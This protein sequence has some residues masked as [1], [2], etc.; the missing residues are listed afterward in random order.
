M[1]INA[2]LRRN[3]WLNFTAQRLILTPLIIGIVAYIIYSTKKYDA[4]A[5]MFSLACFFIFLWGTKDASETVIEEI[6]NNT[7]DFQR[8]STISPWSMTWGKLMGSTLF[9]WYGAGISLLLY[10]LLQSQ[11]DPIAFVLTDIITLIL[12]G[13]FAQALSLLL[14]L[15]GLSLVR[16]HKNIKSFR[17]YFAGTIIGIIAS[18]FIFSSLKDHHILWHGYSFPSATFAICS[19]LI[20]IGWTLLGLQRSF[21]KELQYQKTPWVWA[22]FTLFCMF[23]F[24]GFEINFKQENKT[25][26]LIISK[27]PLLVAFNVAVFLTY[28]ALLNDSINTVRYKKFFS[29]IAQSHYLEAAKEL[30]LWVIS[31]IAAIGGGGFVIYWLNQFTR[32]DNDMFNNFQPITLVMT[33]L[34]FILRDILLAHYFYFRSNSGRTIGTILIYLFLAYC[35]IPFVLSLISLSQLTPMFL[36]SYGQNT[37]LAFISLLVQIVFLG[38]LCYQQY[39]R[40][41][42]RLY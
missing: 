40:G 35:L 39:H 26:D 10:A 34:L 7:W 9:S 20:F 25:L 3:I 28:V 21:C 31:Y 32:L 36:P 41:W 22:L 24:S 30:P 15:Q 8:Q 17:Y 12:C 18:F 11:I 13:I 37:S 19:L 5:A 6:N 42:R 2:E 16:S 27:F 1:I 23:Y 38:W 4:G 29:R 33:T 14:S